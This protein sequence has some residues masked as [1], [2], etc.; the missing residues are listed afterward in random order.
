MPPVQAYYFLC[1]LLNF[2]FHQ[3]KA[4]GRKNKKNEHDKQ[5]LRLNLQGLSNRKIAEQIG[6]YKGTVNR[7]I[8]KQQVI[9]V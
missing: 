2:P 5:L 6:L 3:E 8:Q 9:A 1:V 4:Y 7:Y